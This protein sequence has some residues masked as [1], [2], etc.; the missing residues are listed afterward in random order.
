MPARH[1]GVQLMIFLSRIFGRPWKP[2]SLESA[3][4]DSVGRELRECEARLWDA[5]IAAINKRSR[6][7]G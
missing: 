1:L 4:L 7:N 6:P 2:S 5:Q 3:I